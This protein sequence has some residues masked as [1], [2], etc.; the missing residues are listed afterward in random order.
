MKGI[1]YFACGL[2]SWSPAQTYSFIAV[3]RQRNKK[4][5]DQI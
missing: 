3:A 2:T 5:A 4:K 1:Y